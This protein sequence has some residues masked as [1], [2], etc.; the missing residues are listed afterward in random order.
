MKR[1][2]RV[3]AVCLAAAVSIGLFNQSFAQNTKD[4]V[5][6]VREIER[7]KLNLVVP[8]SFN[9]KSHSMSLNNFDE[10]TAVIEP[11]IPASFASEVVISIHDQIRREKQNSDEDI[12][13]RQKEMVEGIKRRK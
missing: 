2:K 9:Y 1:E 3:T 6:T 8:Q 10:D 12:M 11:V 5:A 13:R 7:K 4:Q